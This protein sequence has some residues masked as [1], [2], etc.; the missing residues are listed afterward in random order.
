MFKV[1]IWLLLTVPGLICAYAFFLRPVLAAMPKFQKFYAEADGF[2][3]TVWAVCGKSA[4]MAWSYFLMLV[5]GVLQWVEPIASA[6]GDPDIKSQITEGLQT[7]PKYLGYF[8]MLVSAIT[9]A[10][11]LRSISKGA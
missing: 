2:W 8:A 10:A 5:G 9:I 4:T 1:A 3:A 6:L 11:R 7:N